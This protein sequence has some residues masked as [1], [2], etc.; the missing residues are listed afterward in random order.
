[1]NNIKSYISYLRKECDLTIDR[2]YLYGSYARGGERDWSDV[3]VCIISP[4]FKNLDALSYLFKNRR[5][6][7]IINSIEPIG[8]SME[9]FY[10]ES[11]LVSEIKKTGKEIKV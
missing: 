1:K 6:Q 8:Y 9:E 7:D 11:P 3:D 5:K 4:K 10:N 2:V